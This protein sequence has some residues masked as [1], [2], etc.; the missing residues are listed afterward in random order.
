MGL[1]L[2]TASV[3]GTGSVFTSHLDTGNGLS[4][5]DLAGN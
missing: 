3:G 1:G 4:M 5:D 2:A